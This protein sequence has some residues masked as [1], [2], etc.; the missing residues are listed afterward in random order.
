MPG[1]GQIP[2]PPP[3]LSFRLVFRHI[4]ERGVVEIVKAC[5]E[6]ALGDQL[7]VGAGFDDAA[8]LQDDNPI[9]AAHGGEPVGDDDAGAALDQAFESRLDLALGPAVDLLHLPLELEEGQT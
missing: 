1:N 2:L 4:V 3:I 5:V 8:V 9:G 7:C 6:P